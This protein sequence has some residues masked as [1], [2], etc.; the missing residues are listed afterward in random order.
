MVIIK[1]LFTAL[2]NIYLECTSVL[3]TVTLSLSLSSDKSKQKFPEIAAA[4][5]ARLNVRQAAGECHF[6]RDPY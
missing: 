1:L 2:N 5:A 6:V 3:I 4:A